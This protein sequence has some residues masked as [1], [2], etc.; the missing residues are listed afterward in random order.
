MGFGDSRTR[1][2]HA[3]LLRLLDFRK[4]VIPWAM[5]HPPPR[6]STPRRAQTV[7]LCNPGH[8]L[9]SLDGDL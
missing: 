7:N 2:A 9:G 6:A 4:A 1:L 3:P 8:L 5:S